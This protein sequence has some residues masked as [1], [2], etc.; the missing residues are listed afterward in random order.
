MSWSRG[1]HFWWYRPFKKEQLA[2]IHF[3][4]I[5]SKLVVT[6][7]VCSVCTIYIHICMSQS[8]WFIIMWFWYQL[9]HSVT[10]PG[11]STW[12]SFYA[13]TQCSAVLY[14][15]KLD[16]TPLNLTW[17]SSTGDQKCKLLTF[18]FFT[19]GCWLNPFGREMVSATHC[20]GY[21]KFYLETNLFC[22]FK[23]IVLK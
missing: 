17:C 11:F 9:T 16:H 15:N 8:K 21:W 10:N 6:N 18:Y 3:C 5:F 12:K 23:T 14:D 4:L 13:K 19:F 22:F 2:H 7:N 1:S 20:C